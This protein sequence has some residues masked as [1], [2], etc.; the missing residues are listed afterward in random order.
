MTTSSYTVNR[1]RISTTTADAIICQAPFVNLKLCVTVI[2]VNK[3]PRFS[4][5]EYVQMKTP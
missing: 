3:G 2:G 5:S 4:L 1:Q